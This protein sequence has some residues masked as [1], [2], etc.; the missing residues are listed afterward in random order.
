MS[1]DDPYAAQLTLTSDAEVVRTRA[2]HAPR[3]LVFEAL[4]SCGQ[5]GRW[6]GGRGAE[7]VSCQMDVR[8]GGHLRFA[9]RDRNGDRHPFLGRFRVVAAPTRLVYSLV[10]DVARWRGNEI[11][12][13]VTLSEQGGVTLLTNATAF[14]APAERNAYR[15]SGL[16]AVAA[17]GYDR[18]AELL[19]VETTP[20]SE[21]EL[22]AARLLDA[23][24][25]LAFAAWTDARKLAYWWGPAGAAVETRRLEPQPGGAYHYGVRQAAGEVRWAKLTYREVLPPERLV[26]LATAADEGGKPVVDPDAGPWGEVLTTL[27]FF[28]TGGR[29]MLIVRARPLAGSRGRAPGTGAARD[30]AAAR[31]EATL[32][33]LARFLAEAREPPLAGP[34]P[35]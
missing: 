26:F 1:G 32:T 2:F 14:A 4:T 33:R 27:S 23:P 18:L 25:D 3:E 30:Q 21:G 17:E 12:V 9:L 6:F 20:A 35:P 22:V 34:V 16:E 29:S 24:P 28:D 13:T 8:P 7:L 19:A 15:A 10:Y 5:L 11:Q 31:L